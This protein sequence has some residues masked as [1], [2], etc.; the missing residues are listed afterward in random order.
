MVLSEGENE[1]EIVAVDHVPR[2]LPMHGDV[3]LSVAVSSNKFAGQ[4]FAWVE[5][6]SLARFLDELRLLENRRQGSAT[7]EGMS[8][9]E[10]RLQIWSVDRRGHVAIGGMIVQQI[11]KGEAAAPYRHSLEF[12]FEFDP[13]ALPKVLAGLVELAELPAT[14]HEGY[15][16]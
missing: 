4:G 13:T 9:D 15:Q 16:P 3:E 2:H 11:F 5:G 7:L 8:P 14:S 1:I 10:F 12:G 6:S